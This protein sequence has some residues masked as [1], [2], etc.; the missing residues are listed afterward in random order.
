MQTR[1]VRRLGFAV[2]CLVALVHATLYPVLW[3]ASM[4]T[5]AILAYE[6]SGLAALVACVAAVAWGPAVER[7]GWRV[8]T[9]A[10]GLTIGCD[11]AWSVSTRL[12]G[13]LSYPNWLDVP[14]LA[15]YVVFIAAI[16]L[17]TGV[18]RPR[19]D[20]RWMFDVA[21]FLVMAAGLGWHF[22]IPAA[23][24]N[25]TLIEHVTASAYLVMD[26]GFLAIVLTAVYSSVLT[27]RRLVV[28]L[29]AVIFATGDI[30]FYFHPIAF[31]NSWTVGLW[32]VALAAVSPEWRLSWRLPRFAH[33][34]LLP[35]ALGGGLT[36]VTVIEMQRGSA[37]DLLLAAVLSLGLVVLRQ[38]VS[39]RQALAA[40][41]R[42]AAFRA[43]LLETQSDL[44]LA[45]LILDAGRVVFAN[46]AA[47]RIS[48][49]SI[50]DLVAL[51]SIADLAFENDR[52]AWKKWLANPLA[53]VE[54]RAARA[55]G[56][57]AD[58]EVVG[59][60]LEPA[61]EGRLLLVTRDI[62]ERR[63]SD[64]A[65]AHAQRLEGLGALAGGVAHDFNNLLSAV[66][67]NVGLLRLGELDAEARESVENIQLAAVRGAELTKRLLEFARPQAALPTV[68]DLRDCLLET[69]ALARPGMPA[70]VHLSFEEHGHP[71]PVM[72]NQGQLTQAFLNLVLNARDAVGESG[73]IAVSMRTEGGVAI[74]EV[75]DDGPGIDELTRRRIFEPFFTTKTAG[76]G[77][78]LGLAITQRT[79]RDHRGTLEVT[80]SPETGAT[81]TVT[82]PLAAVARAG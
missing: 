68:G 79:V 3:G 33:A 74:V 29:A 2:L 61:E 4:S 49:H 82:L 45:L 43:A 64:L 6:V 48:G 19:V 9:I 8:M 17:L 80:S 42:D 27:L 47:E 65:V 67:G 53:T 1:A 38:I 81:F 57:V 56:T 5:A 25:G 70:N 44:G 37:D 13:E 72:L 46:R 54:T 23:S 22:V 16:G 35:Y 24:P 78:G 75:S 39:L 36:L 34:H 58:L 69:I 71:V 77:T 11:V 52:P 51:N 30:L 32:L 20:G 55:D 14:Y 63:Q 7:Q 15:S 31:D 28:M 50:K 60:W 12:H 66:L 10:V 76:A 59:R 40:Q 21:A 73:S 26:L 18:L 62:T 41:Q